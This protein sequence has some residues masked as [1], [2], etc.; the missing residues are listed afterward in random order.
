M[1]LAATV[2]SKIRSD[3]GHPPHFHFT[4]FCKITQSASCWSA[5]Q[6]A[7]LSTVNC[8]NLESWS[9]LRVVVPVW[10]GIT[11]SGM[12]FFKGIFTEKTS[13]TVCL[14]ATRGAVY[15][16]LYWWKGQT[17][18]W[19]CNDL[20]SSRIPFDA[21]TSLHTAQGS[22]TANAYTNQI[23]DHYVLLFNAHQ[24]ITFQSKMVL[25]FTLSE[26]PYDLAFK[27]PRSQYE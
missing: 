9:S 14:P 15:S 5:G 11:I 4:R 19:H 23:V 21:K 12:W 26:Q 10:T 17:W 27:K 1:V 20:G 6:A 7:D 24:G 22:L 8:V 13:R 18:L 25:T 2:S 3:Y 16:S